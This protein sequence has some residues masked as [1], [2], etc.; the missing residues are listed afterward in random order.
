MALTAGTRLGPHEILAPLEGVGEAYLARDTRLERTV[1]IKV[2]PSHWAET[3][4][5]KDRLDRDAKL[6]AGLSHPSIR[7]L[8]DI[9]RERPQMPSREEAAGQP[10]LPTASAFS[11]SSSSTPS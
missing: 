6:I 11:C 4:E 3:P 1:V 9:G 10:S 8:H 5:L 2:I 7:A